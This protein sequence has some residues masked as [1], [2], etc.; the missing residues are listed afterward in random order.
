M[1]LATLVAHTSSAAQTRDL[2]AALAALARPGDLVL[3]T[4]DLGAGKTTFAQGFGRAL[5]V[6]EPITSP[7][8]TLHR[9]YH[10][11][12]RLEH[13]DVYRLEQL[14]EVAD[15][16]LPELL[17]GGGVTLIEWGDTI[18]PA[19][20]GDRLEV[21]LTLA[22][23][24]DDRVVDLR[25]S[26]DGWSARLDQLAAVLLPWRAAAEAE[27][28]AGPAAAGGRAGEDV[29]PSADGPARRG[30]RRAAGEAWAVGEA[31]PVGEARAC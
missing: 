28:G 24:D 29:A 9:R 25:P 23:G 15:L 11:R 30:D 14:E 16:D 7:T 6:S 8:F 2:A 3:L 26:G 12:L 10:G 21:R 4:G 1:S 19:L 13:L 31:R 22:D 17:E 27:A 5:G 18:L 20:P